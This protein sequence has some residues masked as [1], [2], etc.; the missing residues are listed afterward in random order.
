[1]LSCSIGFLVES[2]VRTKRSS[3]ESVP[4]S[5]VNGSTDLSRP[6]LR[7][8]AHLMMLDSK[9]PRVVDNLIEQP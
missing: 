5:E 3:A 1:M 7:G 8:H 9:F 6:W 2:L 4:S